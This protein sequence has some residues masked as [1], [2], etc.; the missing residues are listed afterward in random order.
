MKY[1]LEDLTLF[2]LGHLHAL[3]NYLEIEDGQANE[4]RRLIADLEIAYQER[5]GMK[6]W[7]PPHFHDGGNA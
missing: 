4:T 3:A 6:A 7:R 2:A 5:T 1:S